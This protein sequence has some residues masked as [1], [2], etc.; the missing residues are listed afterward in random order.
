MENHT[1]I[2]SKPLFT[3]TIYIIKT[4]FSSNHI[5]LYQ[6][7]V[8]EA[9]YIYNPKHILTICTYIIYTSS[10]ISISFHCTI[11]SLSYLKPNTLSPSTSRSVKNLVLKLTNRGIS[12]YINKQA[13]NRAQTIIYTSLTCYKLPH[14]VFISFLNQKHIKVLPSIV[15]D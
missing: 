8:N 6:L 15:T 1:Y 12:C 4:R 11:I 2:L 10:Y 9:K 14:M 13:P 3:N 5:I 7:Y